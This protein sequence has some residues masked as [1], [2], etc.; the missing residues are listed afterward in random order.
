MRE[1]ESAWRSRV[2]GGVSVVS[3]EEMRTDRRESAMAAVSERGVESSSG[4]GGR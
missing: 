1:G 3:G 4:G 2:S